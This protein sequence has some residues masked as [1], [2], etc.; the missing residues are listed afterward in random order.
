MGFSPL[1]NRPHHVII[2]KKPARKTSSFFLILGRCKGQGR[3]Q[4][5]EKGR[6]PVKFFGFAKSKSS[7]ALWPRK[8]FHSVST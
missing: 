5:V 4:E 8:D 6:N 1:I 3:G 2:K 7:S